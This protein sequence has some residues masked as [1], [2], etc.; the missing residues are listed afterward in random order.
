MKKLLKAD[1]LGSMS[2]QPLVLQLS[3][4]GTYH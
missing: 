4:A 3:L 2:R 1:L